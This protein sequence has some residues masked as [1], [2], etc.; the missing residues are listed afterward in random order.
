MRIG[1]LAYH[2]AINFG[3]TLQLLFYIHVFLRI[4]DMNL[5]S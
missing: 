5:L 2:S 3:A 1:L 4:M